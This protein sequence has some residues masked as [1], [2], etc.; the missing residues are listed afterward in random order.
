V[1]VPEQALHVGTNELVLEWPAPDWD[2]ERHTDEAADLMECSIVPE[3]LPVFGHLAAFSAVM[4]P[5]A[6]LREVVTPRAE[7]TCS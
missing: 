1:A 3:I 6:T 7:W 2:Q 5:P 4:E